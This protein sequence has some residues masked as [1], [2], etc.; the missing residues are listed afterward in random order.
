MPFPGETPLA[1]QAGLLQC[2]MR[3]GPDQGDSNRQ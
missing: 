1:V 2:V 3:T